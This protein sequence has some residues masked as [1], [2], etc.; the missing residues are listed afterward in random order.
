MS[1]FLL[2]SSL[3]AC[4]PFSRTPTPTLPALTSTPSPTV[5]FPTLPPTPTLTPAPSLTP[6]PDIRALLGTTL[7]HD[8]FS[9]DQGWDL[10]SDFLGASSLEAGR[11]VLALHQTGTFRYVLVPQVRAQDFY[12]QVTLRAELCNP[13]DE[14]GVMIRFTPDGENYR[15]GL[16]CDGRARITR[17]LSDS[18]IALVLPTASPL[19]IPGA[20]AENVLGVLAEGD[21]LRLFINGFEAFVARDRVLRAGRVAL[22]VRASRSAQLTVA[23]D[24][25]EITS[26]LPTPTPATPTRLPTPTP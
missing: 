8:D 4:A 11:L 10:S 17:V 5:G 18:S 9:T 23:F 6:T 3:C 2:G 14:F 1:L 12:L 7:F 26:L 15:I 21:T 13:N 20:P 16:H 22:F 19:I 25:L 24:N